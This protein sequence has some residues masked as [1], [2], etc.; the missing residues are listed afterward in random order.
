[1]SINSQAH[2]LLE[3]QDDAS[4]TIHD[5]RDG[6]E[7]GTLPCV[8]REQVALAVSLARTVQPEW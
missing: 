4:I 2:T 3:L 6:S 1:M 7:V 8:A 5:P